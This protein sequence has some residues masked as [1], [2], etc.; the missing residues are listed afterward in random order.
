MSTKF[1]ITADPLIK[2]RGYYY[3]YVKLGHQLVINNT[4]LGKIF[5]I[6]DDKTVHMLLV[7][8][9][10]STLTKGF[11]DVLGIYLNTVPRQDYSFFLTS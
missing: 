5:A 3:R 8:R 1:I 9:L 10:P 2:M 4:K 11:F 7:Y 6:F